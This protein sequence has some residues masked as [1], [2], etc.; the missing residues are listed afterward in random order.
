MLKRVFAAAHVERVAVREEGLA[1]QLLDHVYHGARVIGTQ[2][3]QVAQLAKVDLD[4]NELVL[5]VDLLY[6]GALDEALELVQLALAA[7]RTQVGE[8]DLS[9]GINFGCSVSCGGIGHEA[10]PF[11]Q[12]FNG[13]FQLYDLKSTLAQMP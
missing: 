8:V 7:V 3:G 4:C 13:V 9:R 2:E 11:T 5:E 12:A 1:A 10:L 6:A